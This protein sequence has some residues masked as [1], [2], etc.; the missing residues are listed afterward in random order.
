MPSGLSPEEVDKWIAILINRGVMVVLTAIVVALVAGMAWLFWILMRGLIPDIRAYFTELK[1]STVSNREELKT[2]V[3]DQ[4][5]FHKTI[6]EDR[7]HAMT[8]THI[9]LLGTKAARVYING[10]THEAMIRPILDEIGEIATDA[11][12]ERPEHAKKIILPQIDR[13]ST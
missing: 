10:H 4:A 8:N 3:R 5:Q 6:L 1:E 11:F 13:P 7:R 2:L 12:I 9:A